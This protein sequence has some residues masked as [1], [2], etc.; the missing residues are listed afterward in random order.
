M[1]ENDDDQAM[2]M[3]LLESLAADGVLGDLATFKL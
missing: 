1:G 2:R 3:K